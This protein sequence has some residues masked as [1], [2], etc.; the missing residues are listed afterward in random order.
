[1][2]SK[3]IYI[4][5]ADGTGKTSVCQELSRHL[6]SKGYKVSIQWMRF[7]HFLAKIVNAVGRLLGLSYRE[8]YD[9]G[10]VIGYHDYYKSPLL[11]FIFTLATVIDSFIAGLIRVIMPLYCRNHIMILDRY[12]YDVLVDVAIDT[13]DENIFTKWPAKALKLILP[14]KA[15]SILLT[16][17]P[18]LALERRSVLKWDKTLTKR[19]RYYNE[20][21]SIEPDINVIDNSKKLEHTIQAID[22]IL[23]YE[24]KEAS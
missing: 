19:M 22:S 7:N 1:M 18:E 17:E 8:T 15:V 10:T 9:D 23:S 13:G 5:G 14:K 20:L 16:L 6:E 4:F 21:A 3:L 12:I 2:T 11:S 24:K